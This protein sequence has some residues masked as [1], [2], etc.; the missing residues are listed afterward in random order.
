MTLN[1]KQLSELCFGAWGLMYT[2]G[3]VFVRLAVVVFLR[4]QHLL[5]NSIWFQILLLVW[6]SSPLLEPFIERIY[7]NTK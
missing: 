3:D 5:S 7:E 6:V 1:K 4:D 2:A